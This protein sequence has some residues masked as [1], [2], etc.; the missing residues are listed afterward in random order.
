MS[1]L[2][3]LASRNLIIINSQ[4]IT[5][6]TKHVSNT[7][8]Y[9]LKST[10]NYYNSTLYKACTTFYT[11]NIL[12]TTIYIFKSTLMI[13]YAVMHQNIYAYPHCGNNLFLVLM[14]T[15]K[16][17]E[18]LYSLFSYDQLNLFFTQVIGPAIFLVV[19]YRVG[20]RE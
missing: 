8:Y 16:I 11:Y 3:L 10:R 18:Y 13:L 4:C 7:K 1:L 14:N 9:T 12:T 20:R 6:L 17:K 5:I 15:H 19:I 2:I